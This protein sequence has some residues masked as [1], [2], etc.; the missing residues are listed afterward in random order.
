MA[1]AQ[2]RR[3]RPRDATLAE[4]RREEF[5]A[6]AASVF[7]RRGYP[8]ADVQEVADACGVS[9]GTV[10]TYF[11]SKEALFLAAVDRVMRQ[12]CAAVRA[13]HAGVADPVDRLEV[14]IRAYLAYFRD[15]PHD[16]ELLIIER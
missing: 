10:Y 3:G 8:D 15:H 5:L 2:G 16:A 11:A 7:A 14:A 9:K 12:M 6:A 13:A 1:V 4:R